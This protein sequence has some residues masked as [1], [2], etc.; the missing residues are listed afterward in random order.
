M[1]EDE[2]TA[3]EEPQESASKAEER[4]AYL[5]EIG[6]QPPSPTWLAE[7]KKKHPGLLTLYFDTFCKG[8]VLAAVPPSGETFDEIFSAQVKAKVDGEDILVPI[9]VKAQV[10][11]VGVAATQWPVDEQVREKIFRLWPLVPYW[12]GQMVLLAAGFIAVPTTET[13]AGT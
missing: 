6:Y 12:V 7:I 3:P 2:T 13:D 11:R 9:A 10:R 4:A 5:T 8:L 1:P